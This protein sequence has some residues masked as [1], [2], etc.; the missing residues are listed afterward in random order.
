MADTETGVSNGDVDWLFR[1]K[2]KKIARKSAPPKPSHVQES[3]LSDKDNV[4][5]LN[6]EGKPRETSHSDST[7]TQS[8]KSLG[9]TSIV[10]SSSTLKTPLK[11]SSQES[12]QEPSQG[13][14]VEPPLKHAP[15]HT[16][17][18]ALLSASK[19]TQKPI[20]NSDQDSSHRPTHSTHQHQSITSHS[21]HSPSAPR[22]IPVPQKP[23]KS[24]ALSVDKSQSRILDMFKFGR[25]RASSVGSQASHLP[26]SSPILHGKSPPSLAAPLLSLHL[27]EN[28]L[29]EAI[30]SSMI[31]DQPTPSVRT[32][33]AAPTVSPPSTSTSR[34]NSILKRLL[35]TS[36]SSK[37]RQNS[38]SESSVS[39]LAHSPT[40][41]VSSSRS[42]SSSTSSTTTNLALPSQPRLNHMGFSIDHTDKLD[43]ASVV[44]KLPAGSGTLSRRRSSASLSRPSTSASDIQR[45]SNVSDSGASRFF[46]KSHAHSVPK[47]NKCESRPAVSA[48]PRLKSV[49]LCRVAFAI[50][51]LDKDPQQQIPSRNPHKGN[52]LIPEDILAPIPRLSQGINLGDSGK[53]KSK[54]SAYTD[55]ELVLAADAQRR[56]RVEAEKHAEE[57]YRAATRIAA[58]VAQYRTTLGLHRQMPVDETEQVDAEIQG[59]PPSS[60]IQSLEI[61]MPIHA[62]TK[63]FQDEHEGSGSLESVY[64]R[65]CHLREILPI[66]ATLK[67]LKN[68]SRPLQVLKLLNPKPTLVDALSFSDFLNITPIIAVIFDNVTMTTEMLGHF[69]SALVGSRTLEKLL[70]R[71]VAIGEQGWLL[72][73]AFILQNRSLR[74]LDIS[75]QKIKPDTKPGCIR[76]AMKWDIFIDA[77][78]ARGGIEELVIN[79][80]VLSDE[81]FS[82]LINKALKLATYRLGIASVALN[83]KQAQVIADWILEP[84]N[85]CCGVDVAF[86]DLSHG[87]LQPF[88]EAFSKGTVNLIFFSL[89]S[90][91]LT[92]IDQVSDLLNALVHVSTLRFLDLS[93]MPDLFPEIVPHLSKFLPMYPSLRRLHLDMNELSERSLCAIGDI[94][95][96][97]NTLCHVSLLGNRNLSHGASAALYNAI[98]TSPSIHTFDLD[99]ELVSDVLAQKMA[100]YLMRNMGDTMNEISAGVQPDEDEDL[101]FDGT[102]LMETAEKLL[103][104]NDKKTTNKD[105][106][107]I[108]SI[109]R[110]A[111][112]ERTNAVRSDVH[113]L[114]ALL[115]QKRNAGELSTEG[116]ERL[117]RFCLLDLSLEKLLP[118]FEEHQQNEDTDAAISEQQAPILTVE[119]LLDRNA[120]LSHVNYP[121]SSNDVVSIGPILTP[122]FT[123]TVEDGAE[124]FQPHQV[125]TEATDDGLHVPVD[126]MTGRPVLMRSLSQTSIHAREQE[127]E[128]GELHR[129]GF[130]LQQQESDTEMKLGNPNLNP[131][132]AAEGPRSA[133]DIPTLNTLPSGSE[134]REAILAAKGIDLV[135]DL[136]DRINRD[137]ELI[138]SL[139]VPK[140]AE[141]IVGDLDVHDHD[142]ESINSDESC[143]QPMGREDNVVVDETLDRLLNEAQRVRLNKQE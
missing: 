12:S 128:E 107:K 24:P 135:T 73:C 96:K 90:T 41:P 21:S 78:V 25:A 7:R 134:L 80:C 140:S 71:N 22:P 112:F 132:L 84:N 54:A 125:V 6:P 29:M 138:E 98:K 69:L 68:K 126:F 142:N 120:V 31:P 130:Y 136:I 27:P 40:P 93:A 15:S 19:P 94:L 9:E 92:D 20:I 88:I 81:V 86:N 26:T 87:Q 64:T 28:Y 139:S 18:S 101:M 99:Y 46:A 85:K 42:R 118:M 44:D 57:A 133:R 91:H 122:H 13:P 110:K 60:H 109:V 117:L 123:G 116:K 17:E 143:E 82:N 106:S 129:L 52:V 76:S 115:F 56:A 137:G 66:P 141:R 61:D 63:N 45:A 43:L 8:S 104:E 114:I 33:H 103:V 32:S 14:S 131:N 62:H 83:T 102:L 48:V 124:V 4:Q 58:Q 50:D 39:T 72:L 70:L 1:G 105:Y 55:R 47:L 75:Q 97:I 30:E 16:T 53:S 74:K 79:G 67:Q 38:I 65:C 49:K 34:S 119:N 95:P 2:L 37:F 5:L 127:A 35:F 23:Q 100:F 11:E 111:L 36:I 77:I 113:R 121:L 10:D 3:K 89:H 59:V 108:Q 51:E